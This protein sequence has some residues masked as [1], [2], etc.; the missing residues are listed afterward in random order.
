MR[1]NRTCLGDQ[2]SIITH[3]KCAIILGF[4]LAIGGQ[5]YEVG[6]YHRNDR[7]TFSL[8]G[9]LIGGC[10]ALA[11]RFLKALDRHPQ[12]DLIPVSE[13]VG[14][15]LRD[16]EDLDKHPFDGMGFDILGKQAIGKSHQTNWRTTGFRSPVFLADGQPYLTRK[17]IGQTVTCESGNETDDA[18]GT[19]LAASARL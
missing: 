16:P 10:L 18:P 19:R 11:Q 9:N 6:K 7:S 3:L 5:R 8:S 2:S 13:A 15:R 1:V 4:S 12:F 14:D 17:L